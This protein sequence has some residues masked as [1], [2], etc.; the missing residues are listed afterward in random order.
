MTKEKKKKVALSIG[1]KINIFATVIIVVM[2]VIIIFLAYKALD[3]N[4]Q[5]SSVL[6]NINKIQYIK[7]QSVSIPKAIKSESITGGLIEESEYPDI[8]DTMVQNMESV[9]NS[10]DKDGVFASTLSQATQVENQL[11]QFRGIFDEYVKVTNGEFSAA[12]QQEVSKLELAGSMVNL[13]AD[14]LM[15]LE[16]SRSMKLKETISKEFTTL[17][18]G[19]IVIIIFC[20]GLFF[21]LTLIIS[22]KISK[23]LTILTNGL[24][25]MASGDLTGEKVIVKTKDEIKVLAEAFNIMK[26]SIT[27][28]VGKVSSVTEQI[29]DASRVVGKSVERNS[30]NGIQVAHDIDNMSKSMNRQ[31]EE[32]KN[33]MEQI[34]VMESISKEI[35]ESANHI[36]GSAKKSLESAMGGDESISIFV[37]Q[38]S[39]V[40]Q[41]MKKTTETSRTLTSRTQE[42]NQILSSISEIAEQTN[43]LSLNASIEAARAGEAGRGFTVVATEIRKLAEDSQ[44]AVE[45]IGSIIGEVQF[46][47]SDMSIKMEEGLEQLLKGNELAKQTKN[48]FDMIKADTKIVNDDVKEILEGIH[49]LTSII[50]KVSDSMKLIGEATDENVA[51]TTD[52]SE[53]VNAEAIYMKEMTNTTS[54]LRELADYLEEEVSKFKL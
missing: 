41:V 48:N 19:I 11:G 20:A 7:V 25:T 14:T 17:I 27:Q 36:S 31:N 50:H 42:M 23:P 53:S 29:E 15:N 5:Y 32:T 47:A 49:K 43:L 9:K 12:G 46:E 13:N 6:E 10:V 44:K 45:K 18:T 26:G 51:A 28:I 37:K 38:L 52:I 3:Y 33:T 35:D 39:N 54:K 30:E 24:E 1:K 34:V 22:R 4:I 2:T 40:N 8:I 16:L 21:I